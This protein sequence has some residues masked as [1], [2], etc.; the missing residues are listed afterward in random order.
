MFRGEIWRLNLDPTVGAEMR[1]TR[2]VVIISD[3]EIG[4]LPLKVVVPVTDWKDRYENVVWMAKVNPNRK[5]NLTKIS[6]VDA[7]QVRCV[8]EQRFVERIGKLADEEMQ[9]ISESLKNVLKIE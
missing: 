3:D 8:S 6:D 9:N 7:F 4:I 5:N 1:K 2:P